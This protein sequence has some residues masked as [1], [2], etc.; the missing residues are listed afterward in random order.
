MYEEVIFSMD[1]QLKNDWEVTC[2]E[3][4]FTTK[5]AFII[6][7]RK[8]VREKKLPFSID[9][10]DYFNDVNMRI[11]DEST[12]QIEEGKFVVKTMEELEAMENE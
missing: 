4:G 2:R 11:I 5:D 9:Y 1:E 7:V 6:F 10:A 8:M 12:R 3:L